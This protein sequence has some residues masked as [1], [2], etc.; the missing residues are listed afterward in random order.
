MTSTISIRFPKRK[1]QR[2]EI[3]EFAREILVS[4]ADV[5]MPHTV[6]LILLFWFTSWVYLSEKACTVNENCSA[7]NINISTLLEK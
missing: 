1:I 6:M 3:V 7:L 5:S 4:I 2:K